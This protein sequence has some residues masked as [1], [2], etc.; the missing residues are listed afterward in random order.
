MKLVDFIKNII[1][2]E[3]RVFLDFASATPVRKEVLDFIYKN[4]YKFYNP[5]GL[6]LESRKSK[7]MLE[8]AK[9]VVGSFLNTSKDNIVFTSS[10]TESNNI[11]ILGVYKRAVSSGIKY[12]HIITSQIEHPSVLESFK[13]LQTLGVDVTFI[14]PE[15]DGTI[16]PEKIKEEIKETTILVSIMHVNNEIGTVNKIKEIGS[17][18]RK[19]KEDRN[20]H[21]PYFHSD[22]SQS[23]LYYSLDVSTLKL[24]LATLDGLKCCGPRGVGILFVSNKVLLDPIFFG[25]GQQS[26]IRSG[27]LSPVNAMA[28]AIAL[29]LAKKERKESFE[30]VSKLR[31]YFLSKILEAFPESFLNGSLSNRSPNNI[32]ICMKVSGKYLDAEYLVVALDTYGVCAS[33][34][35]SCM[36]DK[37]SSTSYVVKS[38]S[39]EECARSSLRFTLGI[40]TTK[41]DLDYTLL[42]LKKAVKQVLL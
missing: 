4:S 7:Q 11:A 18:I 31:D 39:N 33:Y 36:T 34:S 27:T 5:N 2:R 15:K 32:N 29:D 1:K 23:S 8:D 20:S 40:N 14:K 13:Y 35:S 19:Y 42:A 37:D 10:G 21:Y 9:S 26:N 28:M 6:Y 12:P 17:L 22:I 24:D 3:K 16:S 41:Q 25:G 38:I 30:E